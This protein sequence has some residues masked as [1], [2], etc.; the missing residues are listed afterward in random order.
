MIKVL[1][2]SASEK[3]KPRDFGPKSNRNNN[4]REQQ[5]NSRRQP[6]RQRQTSS[7]Q[8]STKSFGNRNEKKLTND[9]NSKTPV[10]ADGAKAQ[11]G[12]PADGVSQ[13]QGGSPAD[14]GTQA[15][16]GSLADKGKQ[17]QQDKP[18]ESNHVT[19]NQ[20]NRTTKR[21]YV[22]KTPPGEGGSTF[23]TGT[24]DTSNNPSSAKENGDEA[25]SSDLPNGQ[26]ESQMTNGT[27]G[28]VPLPQRNR[29]PRKVYYKKDPGSKI[30]FPPA[31]ENGSVSA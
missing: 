13:A 12:S 9:K 29:R 25:K 30:E 20:G 24:V 21:R 2:F 17:A 23:R 27:N 22:R 10:K 26:L 1:C 14:K 7:S 15:Q 31:R 6:Q 5:G 11:D 28:F 4:G 18:V 3:P 19:P 8:N 16:D